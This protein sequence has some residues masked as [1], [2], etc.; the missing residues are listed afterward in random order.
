MPN[1]CANNSPTPP[2]STPTHPAPSP[3]P[4]TSSYQQLKTLGL[5]VGIQGKTGADKKVNGAKIQLETCRSTWKSQQWRRDS[6]GRLVNRYAGKCMEAG[7]TDTLYAKAFVWD[8]HSGQH[9]QWWALNNGRYQNKKYKGRYLGVAYCGERSDYRLLELRS[10]ERGNSQ[11]GCA[12]K[13]N[14]SC[15]TGSA[16]APGPG[17]AP[18]PTPPSP[19]SGFCNYGPDGT[20]ATSDCSGG[21]EGG[22][23]CNKSGSNCAKCSGR[24]C[25]SWSGGGPAPSPSSGFCN[26]GPDGTGA[27]SD[28]SGGAEGGAWCNES[29]ANCAKCSGRWCT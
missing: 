5:C 24:W 3:T 20:G 17:P 13:W 7:D 21:A 27:T 15:S 11:C 2:V 1:Y 4:P 23:W 26:Y 18:S 8:C 28:C 19:S 14:K 29:S 10:L 25:T 6:A 22:A 16:P 9:Q 12:Q